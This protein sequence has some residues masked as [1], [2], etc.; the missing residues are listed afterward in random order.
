LAAEFAELNF[1]LSCS[2]PSKLF[3]SYPSHTSRRIIGSN[4]LSII[5]VLNSSKTETVSLA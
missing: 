3:I 1:Q 2:A 4:E 5:A